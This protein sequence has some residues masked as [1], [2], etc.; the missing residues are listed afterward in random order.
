MMHS[1]VGVSRED[2]EYRSKECLGYKHIQRLEHAEVWAAKRN[3]GTNAP[4]Y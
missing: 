4:G 2:V 1:V 3:P